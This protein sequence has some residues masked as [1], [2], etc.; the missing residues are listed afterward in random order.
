MDKLVVMQLIQG[1]QDNEDCYPVIDPNTKLINVTTQDGTC[2]VNLDSTFLAP[3]VNVSNDVA[4]YSIVDS[5]IELGSVN[6]VQF[7][8]D[9]DSDVMFR[10][11]V[12]LNTQFDRNLDIVE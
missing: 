6:K 9:S 7:L 3:G 8:I 10:E 2:Y 1:P 5:L 11:T 4:I 12:S